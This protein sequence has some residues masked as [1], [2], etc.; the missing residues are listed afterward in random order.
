[1][2]GERAT[3]RPADGAGQHPQGRNAEEVSAARALRPGA[4]GL[5]G[6]DAHPI[7]GGVQRPSTRSGRRSPGPI[8]AARRCRTR[9][10]VRRSGQRPSNR[11]VWAAPPTT[12]PCGDRLARRRARGPVGQPPPRLPVRARV[13]RGNRKR[14]HPVGF[15]KGVRVRSIGPRVLSGAPAPLR[16]SDR[17]PHGRAPLWREE[18]RRVRMN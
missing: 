4:A 17:H 7:D 13:P 15:A 9:Q 16:Q 2:G 3:G 8:S 6:S 11:A 5:E 14:A 18:E 12:H 1:M 10:R